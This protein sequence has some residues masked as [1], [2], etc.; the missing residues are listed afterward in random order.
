MV[1]RVANSD[2]TI[3]FFSL[4][5]LRDVYSTHVVYSELKS[6]SFCRYGGKSAEEFTVYYAG[7]S[8]GKIYKISRWA[9]KEDGG[10]FKSKLLDV[11]EATPGEPV[12]AMAISRTTK[13]LYVTSDS[14]IRQFR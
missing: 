2:T 5:V 9:D 13:M 12:R 10:K 8:D 3:I 4:W 6:M 14:T 11:I 7:T 1:P